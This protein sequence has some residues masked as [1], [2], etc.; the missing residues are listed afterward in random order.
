MR[1][2]VAHYREALGQGISDPTAMAAAW[3]LLRV[4]VRTP[5]LA[6][7]VET[8]ARLA[9][10]SAR[11]PA[12]PGA[13]A[14][15]RPAARAHRATSPVRVRRLQAAAADGDR[16]ALADLAELERA[17]GRLEEAVA[18]M[19][20]VIEAEPDAG[21]RA[22]RLHRARRA[23]PR[24]SVASATRPPPTQRAAEEYPDDPRAARALER[25]Q[26]A[27]GGKEAALMRHLQAAER[28]PAR[29]P[30]ELTYAAR[31]LRELGRHDEALARLDMALTAA[32]SLG[33]ALDL[34]VELQ[35][36]AGRADEAAAVLGRAAD[37]ER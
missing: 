19:A 1:E 18:A 25:T 34:A 33:P 15:P 9:E 11:G 3:G 20:R 5:G 22:D 30:M 12:A 2:A 27:G 6:D 10:L 26:A 14:A 28:S 13:R 17:D 36:A 35:L 29:A 23:R 7:D 8:H 16:V 31:L 37:A 4:A 24:S 32:P 21:R